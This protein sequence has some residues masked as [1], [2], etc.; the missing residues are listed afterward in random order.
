[1]TVP[2]RKVYESGQAKDGGPEPVSILTEFPC[3][4]EEREGEGEIKLKYRN[5]NTCNDGPRLDLRPKLVATENAGIAGE[6]I[7]ERRIGRGQ[8]PAVSLL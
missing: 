2:Y 3:N 4:M 8:V 5:P 6:I 1:M 7:G